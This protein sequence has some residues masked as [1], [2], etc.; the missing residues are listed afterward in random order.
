[1]KTQNQKRIS[2]KDALAEALKRHFKISKLGKTLSPD[3]GN[4]FLCAIGAMAKGGMLAA[5]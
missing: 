3:E 4:Y 1:M 5:V 2:K